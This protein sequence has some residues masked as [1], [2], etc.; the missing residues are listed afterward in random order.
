MNKRQSRILITVFLGGIVG[1]CAFFTL[2]LSPYLKA[3]AERSDAFHLLG[4]CVEIPAGDVLVIEQRGERREIR[5][6]GIE[7]PR[8]DG[9]TK[10]FE[11]ATRLEREP[12]WVAQQG[13]VAR[14]TLAAWIY[15][16][17]LHITYPWGEDALDEQGRHWAYAAVAGVDISRKLLQGGQVFAQTP[18][19]PHPHA[20]MY[21]EMEAQARE[22]ALGIWRD[23]TVSLF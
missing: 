9:D 19:E 6:I 3:A 18:A 4:K 7:A 22:R 23:R 15:R 5:L 17:G 10:L 20:E 2:G 16:R 1:F 11:Q 12:Q 21:V 8:M 14:N 13:Q